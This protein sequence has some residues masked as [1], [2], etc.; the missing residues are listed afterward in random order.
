MLG[1]ALPDLSALTPEEVLYRWF[2][3]HLEGAGKSKRVRNLGIDIFDS[4][5]YAI[6]LNQIAPETSKIDMSILNVS[7]CS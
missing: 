7:A 4:E 3:F 1:E 5:A 2:N 6:L